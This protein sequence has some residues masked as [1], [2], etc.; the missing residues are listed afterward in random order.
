MNLEWFERL[1]TVVD[2]GRRMVDDQTASVAP[3][4]F[5]ALTGSGALVKAG[6]RINWMGVLKRAAVDLWDSAEN[7]PDNAPALWEDIAYREGCRVI[8]ESITATLAFALDE[9]GWWKGTKYR[10]L[11]AGNTHTPADAPDVW[12]EVEE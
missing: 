6:T 5:D 8:P 1:H 12:Q 7:N 10:S 3:E 9:I 2:A 4:M 11:K